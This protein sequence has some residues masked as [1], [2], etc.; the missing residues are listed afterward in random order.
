[1]ICNIYRSETKSGL[2]LYL[3]ED[4]EISDLPEELVKLLGKHTHAMELDLSIRNK[5]ANE[6]I[7]AVKA[8]L[9]DKGYHVQLPRDIVKDV[10][11]YT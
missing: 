7:E 1:M 3:K 10:L 5:L 11:K 8:N 6:E 4:K 9:E 2:Y